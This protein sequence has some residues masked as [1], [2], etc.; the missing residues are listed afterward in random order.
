MPQHMRQENQAPVYCVATCNSIDSMPTELV[1]RFDDVFFVDLP[2]D[3]ARQEIFGIHLSKR[4]QNRKKFNLSE[5]GAASDGY[6]GRDIER[7]VRRS[8]LKAL[9]AKRPMRTQ[10]LIDELAARIPTL[11]IKGDE[12]SNMREWARRQGVRMAAGGAPPEETKASKRRRM[13]VDPLLN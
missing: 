1:D 6:S 11:K 10:D 7:V 5:L 2:D 12:I 8:L 9:Q 13:D 4:K 3:T